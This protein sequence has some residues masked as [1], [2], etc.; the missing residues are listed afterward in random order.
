MK[1]VGKDHI[2][3]GQYKSKVYM[4]P[5]DPVRTVLEGVH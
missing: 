3:G 5:E 4:G 1:V 2:F